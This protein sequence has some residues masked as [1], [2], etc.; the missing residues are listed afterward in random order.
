MKCPK[1]DEK[2]DD[3]A[4][5]C[6]NCDFILDAGFLGDDIT[7]QDDAEEEVIAPGADGATRIKAADDGAT[8]TK[9]AAKVAQ[10]PRPPPLPK[11]P[12][13][14]VRAAPKGLNDNPD[15]PT[16]HAM[17]RATL[18]ESTA[19]LPEA[20]EAMTDLVTQFKGM[21]K[22]DQFTLGGAAAI[23]VSMA[24]PWR[25][26]RDDDAIIGFAAGALHIAFFAVLSIAAVILR[27]HPK[28]APFRDRV[29]LAGAGSGLLV[30]LSIFLFMY[31]A[32]VVRTLK[33]GGRFT[34]ITEQWP[35][36]GAYVAVIAAGVMVYGAVRAYLG[37]SELRD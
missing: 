22:L 32:R 15:D 3:G 2:V 36:L 10:K 29:L 23:L 13:K 33:N 30:L 12:E 21:P 14:S 26:N 35:T 6:P 20:G 1:C 24:L 37:R 16:A 5:I 34:Y 25:T 4:F 7:N 18:D 8:K 31:S 19:A 9:P 11:H 17:R 27:R 28:L